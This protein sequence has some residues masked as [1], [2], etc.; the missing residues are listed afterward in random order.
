MLSPKMQAAFNTQIQKELYSAYLYLSMST[1]FEAKNLSGFAKWLTVQFQEEQGHALKFL[2]YVQE[3]GGAIKL[4]AI[5]Q[6]PSEWASSLAAF[7]NVLEHEQ[8]VTASINALYEVA[9]AEKDYASQIL[10]QWFI[11]EQV[12]EEKNASDIIAQLKMIDAHDTAVLM[13]DKALG[14]RGAD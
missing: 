9:L 7:E 14:K 4:E 12:E 3:R 1:Y 5:Q 10:L 6:P 8:Y 2:G 13:L 11:S